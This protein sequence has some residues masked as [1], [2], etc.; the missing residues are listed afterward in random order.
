MLTFAQGNAVNLDIYI[1][2]SEGGALVDPD[3][4]A[5]GTEPTLKIYDQGGTL[6][7]EETDNSN[8]TRLAEGHYQFTGYT[9]PVDATVGSN[10]RIVWYFEVNGN[11]IA[12]TARTEY[13]EVTTGG[14]AAYTNPYDSK[15]EV[16]ELVEGVTVDDIKE[17]WRDWAKTIIDQECQHDFYANDAGT[18]VHDID[19]DDQ[20]TV[21]L[22][23]WP[24]LS[25]TR[26]R[27][28]INGVTSSTPTTISSDHYHVYTADGRIRLVSDTY[29]YFTKGPVNVDVQY[30]YGYTEVPSDVR[31]LANMLVAF[32]A[33]VWLLEEE[34]ASVSALGVKSIVMA[35]YEA[36]F[37]QDLKM[38]ESKFG[39]K[40]TG[41]VQ[42]MM[43]L[44]VQ[45]YGYGMV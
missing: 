42:R 21:I 3:G 31:M 30:T 36:T 10:W 12:A 7:H 29:S 32:R 15:A 18:E 41:G 4:Y 38:V 16:V 5:G 35:D 26:L 11:L 33:Q 39:D 23:H 43:K 19:R 27:D 13:F 8:I 45:K 24:V 40:V 9:L 17:T 34:Q 37:G 28:C 6:V 20:D 2:V 44:V 1:Y 25:V 22:R 14:A